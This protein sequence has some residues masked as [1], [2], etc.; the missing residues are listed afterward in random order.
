VGGCCRRPAGWMEDKRRECITVM[1]MMMMQPAADPSREKK[2]ARV[3]HRQRIAT[4]VT[5][6]TCQHL[7]PLSVSLLQTLDRWPRRAQDVATAPAGSF[8]RRRRAGRGR[9]PPWQGCEA[10]GV[11]GSRDGDYGWRFVPEQTPNR[12]AR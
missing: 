8:R 4:S 10:P 12:V 3:P 5:I 11:G 9:W 7:V 2:L 6:E 1:M